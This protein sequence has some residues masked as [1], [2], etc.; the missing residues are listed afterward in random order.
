MKKE[1]QSKDLG[2][3]EAAKNEDGKCKIGPK[4]TVFK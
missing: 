1:K 2:L 3:L 4:L